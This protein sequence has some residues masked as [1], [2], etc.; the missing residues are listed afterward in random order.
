M[1]GTTNVAELPAPPPQVNLANVMGIPAVR[2]LLALVGIAASVAAGLAVFNWSQ[3]PNF[4][5]VYQQLEARDAQAVAA[6]LDA[7]GIEYEINRS[8]G[9]VEVRSDQIYQARMQLAAQGLPQ[10]ASIG[11]ADIGEGAG[12]GTSQFAENARYNHALE[13]ELSNTIKSLRAVQNAR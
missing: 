5:A 6:S 10:S 3:K 9:A 13:M 2:Q 4:T 8:T 7:A 11:M 1:E 12:F